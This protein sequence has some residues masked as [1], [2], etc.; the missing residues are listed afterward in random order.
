MYSLMSIRTIALS[1]SNR[2]AA[3][4]RASS[5]LPTPV[6]PRNRN[7]PIGRRGSRSP[8]RARRTASDTA[9]IASSWP[10]TRS[11]S[12]SS[13]WTSLAVSPSSSLVTGIPV[14]APTISAMSS[15]VTSSL[16]RA[17]GPWSAASAASCSLSR[18][19]SSRQAAVLEL[20]GLG[21]VGLALGLLDP[22]LERLEL[23]LRGPDRG[24]GGLLGL[25]ALLHRAGLLGQLGQLALEGLEARLRG[26]VLLLAQRL[27]LDLE[28][29]PP[30]LE[31]VELDRH[32]V[33]LHPEPAG[34]LVDEVDRLVR[35]EALG[36]VAV[37][38]GRR[39]DEGRVGDPD[40]VM[41]L[42]ALAQAAQDRDR[43]LDAS[44]ARR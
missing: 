14:Q 26:V 29:D 31:L 22:R 44:A 30:A 5:V 7:E 40:A 38:Q 34:G 28:L 24:D 4:A 43:L 18:A 33:D 15:A 23:G 1:S 20:G 36:D 35:Q 2:N 19:W 13:M 25:P 37:R 27:A 41:D 11:W 39:G 12:R 21:V 42:V 6:G 10:T 17:P 9:S 32:R 3:S 16:S 8:A